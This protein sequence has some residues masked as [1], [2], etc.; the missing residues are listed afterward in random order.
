MAQ[1]GAT[2]PDENNSQPDSLW[3]ST[4]S[5]AKHGVVRVVEEQIADKGDVSVDS[6][7]LDALIANGLL[8]LAAA[9]L[10]DVPCSWPARYEFHCVRFTNPRP[11]L[12][13]HRN[14]S[15]EFRLVEETRV[16]AVYPVVVTLIANTPDESRAWVEAIQSLL[17]ERG[18]Q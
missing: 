10:S 14:K 16:D 13:A 18:V 11:V 6:G 3:T 7:A 15:G 17:T 8:R 2:R 1:T 4:S 12:V 9:V 5:H